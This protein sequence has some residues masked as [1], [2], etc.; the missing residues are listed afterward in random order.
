MQQPQPNQPTPDPPVAQPKQPTGPQPGTR[1]VQPVTGSLRAPSAVMQP[2]PLTQPFTTDERCLSAFPNEL[3]GFN[4]GI[5][6]ARSSAVGAHGFLPQTVAY[7]RP[8]PRSQQPESRGSQPTSDSTG[9][10]Q[11]LLFVFVPAMQITGLLAG[12]DFDET[13]RSLAHSPMSSLSHTRPASASEISA[14]VSPATGSSR[15]RH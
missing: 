4:S 9:T 8:L 12:I 3:V 1:Q 14:S 11:T 6:F 5:Y 2:R 10:R 13:R 15:R 7:S